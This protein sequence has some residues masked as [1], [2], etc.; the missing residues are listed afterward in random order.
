MKASRKVKL[1]LA[2]LLLVM[3]A[4]ASPSPAE[5]LPE[6]P[7]EGS[8][9]FVVK[10]CLR[11]H[12]IQGEGGRSGPDLGKLQLNYSF[13]GMAGVMWYH[14]PKMLKEFQRLGV[15][16]PRFQREE[17]RR[18]VS[19]LYYLNYFDRKGD[20]EVGERLFGER[21]CRGCHS[22]GGKGGSLGPA[23][24]KYRPFI[25]PV[26]ITAAMWNRGKEME[27]AMRREGVKRPA[28][29]GH[30]ILDLVAYIRAKSTFEDVRK[31]VYLPPGNALEGRRL[32]EEK[33]CSRCHAVNGE[34]GDVGPDLGTRALRRSVSTIA[35][36]LWNH[37]RAMWRAMERLEIERPRLEPQEL[38][39]IITYL[40]F[41]Q[42]ADPPGDPARG[43]RLFQ[44]KGCGKCHPIK[45]KG[46][47]K[48]KVGPNL[49][50]VEKWE[51][52]LDI[53][54][55]MWNHA[56]EM[57]E[58]TWEKGVLWPK[59]KE[60][61]LAHILEYVKFLQKRYQPLGA[62]GQGPREGR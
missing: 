52:S 14:A 5:L 55:E 54:T 61:E 26:F 46:K 38:S 45:G 9:L 35:G 31:R 37:G 23:L 30:E 6:N 44:E 53:V 58:K 42:Y 43:E 19:F 50:L 20:P 11:C 18:L 40:Y 39:D 4:G 59:L 7:T 12:A 2:A 41:I 8:R 62:K 57:E 34:G 33:G 10:G 28:F 48:D 49:A 60:D 24:D 3:V 47:T 1:L 56:A 16:R 21:G 22:V 15:P 13:L 25:S 36:I 32:F 29:R 27:E 51:S 17:M